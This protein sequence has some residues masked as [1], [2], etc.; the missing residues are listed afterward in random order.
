[1]WAIF[2]IDKFAPNCISPF[3]TTAMPGVIPNS[4]CISSFDDL[5]SFKRYSYSAN[6][7]SFA[8]VFISIGILG[9]TTFF[10]YSINSN[11]SQL[12]DEE[13]TF[14]SESIIPGKTTINLAMR[15]AWRVAD[16]TARSSNGATSIV[17]A[18]GVRL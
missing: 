2:P 17:R 3:C 13:E 10:T 16:W 1:M 6:A 4:R 11:F 7:A 18:S 9:G 5:F 12:S 15:D 8:T 14:N